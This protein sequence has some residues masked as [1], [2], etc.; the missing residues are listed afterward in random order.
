MRPVRDRRA[1]TLIEL[2]VVMLIISVLVGLL[3]PAVNRAREAARRSSCQNNMKQVALAVANYESQHRYFPS[4]WKG[5][6]PDT[7][8]NIDGWSVLGQILP[9][10]E[11]GNLYSK[12][13]VNTF[14]V[15]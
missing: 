14:G 8:G 9:H 4:S 15:Y 7:T 12:I 3:L 1:F 13:D 10:L 2:L 5:T 11:Q 6:A